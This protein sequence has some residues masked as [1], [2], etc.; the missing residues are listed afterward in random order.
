M[1]RHDVSKSIVNPSAGRLDLRSMLPPPVAPLTENAGL[2][3]A[4]E[5]LWRPGAVT[6]PQARALLAAP[7]PTGRPN[8]DVLRPLVTLGRTRRTEHWQVD[9]PPHLTAAEA[10]LYVAPFARLTVRL[11]PAAGAF[12]E[13]PHR[14]SALRTALARRERSG[15]L[16]LDRPDP[17]WHWIEDDALPGTGLLAV[18]R[19]DDFTAGLLRSNCFRRWWRQWDAPHRTVLVLESFPFPWPPGLELS[20]LTG[21]QQEQRFALARAARSGDQSEIDR[22]ALAAYGWPGELNDADLLAR[23]LARHHQRAG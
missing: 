21:A 4:G 13:N 8:H 2:A 15:V 5:T 19:D 20:A 22:A 16:P 11:R 7:N 3:F 10:G 17:V 9:F 18:A 14:D 12:W 23:L 6:A 1:W